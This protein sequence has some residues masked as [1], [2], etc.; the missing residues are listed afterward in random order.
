MKKY[1]VGVIAITIAFMHVLGL[2]QTEADTF[3]NN[4]NSTVTVTYTSS[5][6]STV[7]VLAE[8]TETEGNPLKYYYK[9]EEGYNELVVPLT[10]GPGSYKI[11]L[12]KLIMGNRA[13]V[14]KKWDTVVTAE[15]ASMVFMIPSVIVDYQITDAAIEKAAQLTAKCKTEKDK[16]KKIYNFVIKNFE[17]DYELLETKTNTAY[18]VPSIND[19]YER[20]LGICYDISAVL[21][22]MLRSVGVEARIVTGYSPNISEYH[23]WNQ[24]YDSKKKEWYTVDGTYDMCKYVSGVRTKMI[25]DDADYKDTIY[26]Y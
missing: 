6:G 26:T 10:E 13:M 12:C 11:R 24:I 2:Y 21:A 25:K 20:R 8:N 17:Y 14:V 19:T 4:G 1:F 15:E 9:L 5:D 16:V 22:G 18:Y 23:A 7:L 3:V